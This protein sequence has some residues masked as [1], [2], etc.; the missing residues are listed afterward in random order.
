VIAAAKNGDRSAVDAINVTG[1]FIGIGLASLVQ[2]FAPERI[3]IGGGLAAAGDF[4]TKPTRESFKKQA[5]DD[6]R[7]RVEIVGSTFDGWE[8]IVG[9]ASIALSPHD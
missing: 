8:G 3:V 1:D 4:L 6:F 9:A 7:D 2:I 5:G